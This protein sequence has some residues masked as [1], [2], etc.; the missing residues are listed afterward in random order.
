M[1]L[2]YEDNLRIEYLS[3]VFDRNRVSNCYK[4]FW[5]MA[6]LKKVQEG[7]NAFSF[8][9]LIHEM[10]VDAW[11]M[12]AE[13][14]LR[15]G[16]NNTTDNLEEVVKYLYHDLYK[17]K[18]ASSVPRD[19]LLEILENEKDVKFTEYKKKLTN[20]VPYCMQTPFYDSMLKNPGKD[21]IDLI[22]RQERLMY[23]F[24]SYQQLKT[25]IVVENEWMGYFIRN[26]EILMNWARYNLVGYL[27]D[28]NPAVPGIVD[29][30]LPPN[31]RKLSRVTRYWETV[32][33]AAPDLKDIYGDN[34]LSEIRVSIDH[35][36][37]WQYVAHDELW[38]LHPT[39]KSINSSKGNHLPKFD[40]YFDGLVNLEYKAYQLRY[41][42]NRVRKAFEDCAAYHVNNAE[43]RKLLY[44]DDL[45]KDDFT[46]RL[47]NVISPVYEAAKNCGFR[48]WEYA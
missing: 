40:R 1:I 28:R 3:R 37:P 32:I 19:R 44:A 11:Y 6:I 5:F 23:Y 21:K 12:V 25:T 22:N 48:E 35:F 9:E 4:Y 26:R 33:V 15:L 42:D 31:S 24:D 7:Q 29:K 46:L 34:T 20:N 47:G 16:P 14:N 17:E 36:V 27:Q 8:D 41:S 13:Y 2:P 43:V 39:T 30:I 38:N 10:I 45:T 18:V